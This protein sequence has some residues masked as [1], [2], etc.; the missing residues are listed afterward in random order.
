MFLIGVWFLLT[1][2]WSTLDVVHCFPSLFQLS[3]WRVGT[4]SPDHFKLT[5]STHLFRG[6]HIIARKQLM[7]RQ[8]TVSVLYRSQTDTLI[9]GISKFRRRGQSCYPCPGWQNVNRILPVTQFGIDLERP[10]PLTLVGQLRA[11]YFASLWAGHGNTESWTICLLN[12]RIITGRNWLKPSWSSRMATLSG[13]DEVL[14]NIQNDL[15]KWTRY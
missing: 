10:Q 1:A 8:S 3:L 5:D 13:A 14:A 15:I 7:P 6:F 12:L 9:T 4:T 11:N 2:Q